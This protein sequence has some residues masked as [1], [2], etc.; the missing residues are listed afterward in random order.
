MKMAEMISMPQLI[1]GWSS[2]SGLNA[3]MKWWRPNSGTS[4]AANRKKQN[5][6]GF[7]FHRLRNKWKNKECLIN[8]WRLPNYSLMTKAWNMAATQLQSWFSLKTTAARQQNY[9]LMRLPAAARSLKMRNQKN[10]RN[11]SSFD[12]RTHVS[13]DLILWY[14][15]KK[16]KMKL[17]LMHFYR[18]LARKWRKLVKTWWQVFIVIWLEW[19]GVD[20]LSQFNKVFFLMRAHSNKY[21]SFFWHQPEMKKNLLKRSDKFQRNLAWLQL[22]MKCLVPGVEQV[23]QSWKTISSGIF[24]RKR[25]IQQNF[26]SK[27]AIPG[28]WLKEEKKCF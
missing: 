28:S 16:K 19:S 5:W 12:K 18:D 2:L 25:K 1:D 24:P 14:Q 9:G 22:L 6:K 20:Q 23:L 10:H 27:G 21:Q 3:A 15:P 26:I 8:A 11:L 13:K 4:N 7:Q 17:I